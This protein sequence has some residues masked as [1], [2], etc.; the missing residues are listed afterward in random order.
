MGYSIYVA[1]RS[2][3][4]Q[5]RMFDF[6]EQHFKYM[7]PLPEASA[8]WLTTDMAYS[9]KVK[10][11]VGFDYKSWISFG[12]RTYAYAVIYWMAQVLTK[13]PHYYYYD[14][15]R[16][17]VPE[18][19]D[20]EALYKFLREPLSRFEQGDAREIAAFIAKERDRLKT[21]WQE[22]NA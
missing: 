1:A 21:L 17:K 2:Q 5:K 18:E 16:E 8:L 12:E 22:E 13:A 20:E 19:E 7:T 10:W 6:L 14:F 3:K 9:E 11:P 15:D 4:D